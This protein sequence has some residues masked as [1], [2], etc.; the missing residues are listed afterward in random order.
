MSGRMFNF[1]SKSSQVN[2]KRDLFILPWVL[3]VGVFIATG[4]GIFTLSVYYKLDFKNT[5]NQDV[6]VAGAIQTDEQFIPSK[7]VIPSVNINSDIAQ[8]KIEHGIFYLQQDSISYIKIDREIGEDLTVIYAYNRPQLLLNIRRLLNGDV[9]IL[10]DNLGEKR[11]YS[12]SL[13]ETKENI[14]T[15]DILTENGSALLLM[16]IDAENNKR[17]LMIKAK[18]EEIS[19]KNR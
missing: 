17:G 10:Y 5:S 16:S 4:L 15:D 12:V 7:I 1:R 18:T 14:L 9:I 19:A 8:G 2:F 6:K 11:S 3:I 13:T